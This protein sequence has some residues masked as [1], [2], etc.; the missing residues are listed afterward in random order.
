MRTVS[1]VAL[2][3]SILG[4]SL[5][6]ASAQDGPWRVS[7]ASGLVD[8][9]LSGTGKT[10]GTAVRGERWLTDRLSVEFGSLLARPTEDFATTTLLAPEAL[11]RYA[12]TDGRFAP[13]VG[14]GG[15][16]VMR[17]TD[18]DTAWDP[19]MTG[20]AGLRV[21]LTDETSIQGEMRLR[22]I[23]RTWAGSSAEW[24]AGLVWRPSGF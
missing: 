14:G 12:F 10:I 20:A 1:L 19:S 6:I 21:R 16:F 9:D 11:V 15:G 13:Y 4:A 18:R 7:L 24:T 3:L 23:G 5:G 2:S 8:Y 22:G 17:H